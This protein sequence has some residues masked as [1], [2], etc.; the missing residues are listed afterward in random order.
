MNSYKKF[1]K[2]A[3]PEINPF[4]R[5]KLGIIHNTIKFFALIFSF[6]CYRLRIS[7]N[8]LDLFGLILLIFSFILIGNAFL[9]SPIRY[10]LIILGY[11][12][13]GFVLFIDFVDGQLAR[14]DNIKYIF[15]SNI[16]DFNPDLLRV[17]LI[18]Y[19]GILS[20]N[21]YIFLFSS[22]SA[23][24]FL[25]LFKQSHIIFV[26]HYPNLIK[27]LKFFFNLRF[28]YLFLFPTLTLINYFDYEHGLL[29]IILIVGFYFLGAITYYYLCSKITK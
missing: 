27:F 23:L 13:I 9:L 8:L 10:D 21:F 3:F 15:G 16:D 7:A 28:L 6:L 2:R 5:K 18:I 14:L 22:L 11:L 26:K 20:A 25:I 12:L 19:P 24:T 29:L 1:L 17:F 4:K